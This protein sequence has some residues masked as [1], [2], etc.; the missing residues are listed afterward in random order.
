VDI[1]SIINKRGIRQTT[2]GNQKRR[3]GRRCQSTGC[4]PK[5]I[6]FLLLTSKLVQSRL[7]LRPGF[8]NDQIRWRKISHQVYLADGRVGDTLNTKE[9]LNFCPGFHI[10]A[11]KH[12]TYSFLSLSLAASRTGGYSGATGAF[13]VAFEGQGVIGCCFLG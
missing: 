9:G 13:Y 2:T 3:W 8:D 7:Q 1:I 12:G 6:F 10:D 11:P 5:K 4:A